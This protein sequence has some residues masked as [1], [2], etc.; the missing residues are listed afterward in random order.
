MM[1]LMMNLLVILFFFGASS[2]ITGMRHKYPHLKPYIFYTL[3]V[4]LLILAS[5]VVVICGLIAVVKLA[6][7]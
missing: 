6:I 7:R 2:V 1:M 4:F 5:P 3:M